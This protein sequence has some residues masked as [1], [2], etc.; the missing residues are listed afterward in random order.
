MCVL[1]LVFFPHAQKNLKRVWCGRDASIM[2]TVF[3]VIFTVKNYRLSWLKRWPPIQAVSLLI[4]YLFFPF[5]VVVV[6]VVEREPLSPRPITDVI[7]VTYT[8]DFRLWKK[9]RPFSLNILLS[10]SSLC[11]WCT[12]CTTT[13]QSR[14]TGLDWKEATGRRLVFWWS[15]YICISYLIFSPS[16]TERVGI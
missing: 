8:A 5:F 14:L 13:I 9:S 15:T 11:C 7:S 10:T 12:Q 6:V 3:S 4:I 2:A 1:L 16:W